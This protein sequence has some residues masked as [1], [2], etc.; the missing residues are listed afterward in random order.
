MLQHVHP[1]RV[2]QLWSEYVKT[3]KVP[4]LKK[5]GRPRRIITELEEEEAVSAYREYPSNAVALECVLR[6]KGINLPHN[7]I[8]T[9]LKKHKLASDQKSKQEV[10][11]IRK[12]AHK[13]AVAYGLVMDSRWRGKWLIVY[14]DDASRFITGWGLFD[15]ATTENTI[16]VLDKAISEYG[17]PAAIL[18]DH[19]SQFYANFGDSKSPGIAAFQEHLSKLRIKHILGR[20][21]HP[22]TNGKVERFF[23]S[24][25]VKLNM[26]GSIGEYIK[27]YNTKRPHMSLDWDNLETPEHA[28]YRKWDKRRRLISTA[29]YLGDS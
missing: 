5:A 3:G 16:S 24:M 21:Q 22:Q 19:G 2:R 10:G 15:E 6:K 9:I 8:H 27:W 23:G 14:I 20:I 26:F 17:K 18:T 25:Q 1:S 13:F 28:F 4:Q 11:K 12:E 29:S 7:M